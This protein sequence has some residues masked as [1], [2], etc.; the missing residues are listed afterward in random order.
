MIV[1]VTEI[2]VE[3]LPAARACEGTVLKVARN[4]YVWPFDEPAAVEAFE[5]LV[6][7]GIDTSAWFFATRGLRKLPDPVVDPEY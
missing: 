3:K 2:V 7:L 4:V 5:G 1:S 6:P